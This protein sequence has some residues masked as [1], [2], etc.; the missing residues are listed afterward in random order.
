MKTLGVAQEINSYRIHS[1]RTTSS[2]WQIVMI[3]CWIKK[4]LVNSYW[5]I[6]SLWKLFFYPFK[7]ICQYLAGGEES[8]CNSLFEM[9][10]TERFW[11]ALF[12][13]L[14]ILL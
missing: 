5:H 10:C 12:D 8:V 7:K 2:N 3:A 13:E 4:Y 6:M 9:H 14:L 11:K 1:Y